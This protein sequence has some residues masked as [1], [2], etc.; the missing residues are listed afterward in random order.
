MGAVV[1]YAF[2]VSGFV[3]LG[4]FFALG[5]LFTRL[6]Y[7]AKMRL[8]AAQPQQSQRSAAHV[9][10][11]G[12]AALLAAVC[13]VF[14]TDTSVGAVAFV[15]AVS[16]SLYDTTATE[17]GLLA[18]GRPL[19]LNTLRRVPPGTRGAV[20]AAGSLLGLLG[21]AVIAGSGYFLGLVGL[22]GAIQSLVAAT[23]AAHLE[24]WAGARPQGSMV[25]GPMM[26]AFH[27]VAAMLLAAVLAGTE[28]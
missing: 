20:S 18:G 14:L 12:I 8:G 24:S 15:A 7:G 28:S 27:T 16:A 10:G 3:L 1:F 5:T 2:G 17:L 19:L 22:A 23:V 9:W 6:G 13:S 21:A 25:S 4:T 11:K 26:N